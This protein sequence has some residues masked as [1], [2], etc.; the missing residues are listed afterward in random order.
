MAKLDIRHAFQLCPV[1]MEDCELLGIHWQGKFYID[2]RLPFGL[3]S[4]PYL[5]NHLADTFEEQ[6]SYS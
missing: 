3:Q 5:C 2:L 4:S 1:S 6:F